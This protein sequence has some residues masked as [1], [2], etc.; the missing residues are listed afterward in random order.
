MAAMEEEMSA[1]PCCETDTKTTDCSH[2]DVFQEVSR[3]PI[4]EDVVLANTS[5]DAL[6]D[7]FVFILP[8]FLLD[9]PIARAPPPDR[10]LHAYVAIK[11]TIVLRT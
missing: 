10:A 3:A 8:E 6:A 5:F 1:M 2:V 9:L 7:T 4:S 11:N